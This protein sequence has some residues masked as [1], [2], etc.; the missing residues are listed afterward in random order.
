MAKTTFGTTSASLLPW[1]GL[2]LILLIADQLT[3]V[4]ILGYYQLGDATYVT[5]F[6]NVVRVH[7]TG[8]AFSFLAS[9]SGWQRWFFTAIG[10][11][12]ALFILWMLKSHARQKLF[13]FAL[14]CILGGAVGNVIDRTLHGY[15]VDFLDFHYAGWHFPA[16][17]V[18]DS[19]ITVGAICLV[20]DELLRVKRS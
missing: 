14:A 11:A 1:L 8:A 7:N 19:A 18:A 5:S 15:V 2:A 3:K 4:L 16:F 9:A 12:A 17:N 20:L 6:F 13:S 10:I